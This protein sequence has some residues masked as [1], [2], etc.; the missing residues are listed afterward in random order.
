MALIRDRALAS[1]PW[2]RAPPVDPP[3]SDTPRAADAGADH[4][5]FSLAQWREREGD[6]AAGVKAGVGHSGPGAPPPGEGGHGGD[7]GGAHE[8]D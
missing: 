2:R 7:A 4:V 1:D 5:L 3:G 8:V 6:I